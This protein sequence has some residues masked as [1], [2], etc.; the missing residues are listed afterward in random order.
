MSAGA[1]WEVHGAKMAAERQDALREFVAVTG[2]EEDRAR[3]F[4]ESAGW[5]LQVALRG[6]PLR[7]VRGMR[8]AESALSSVCVRSAQSSLPGPT[9]AQASWSLG[10][11]ATRRRLG[12]RVEG[13]G[14]SPACSAGPQFSCGLSV[15]ARLGCCRSPRGGVAWGRGCRGECLRLAGWVRETSFQREPRLGRGGRPIPLPQLCGAGGAGGAVHGSQPMPPFC[16]I[17]GRNYLWD[18]GARLGPL[19]FS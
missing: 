19:H 12:L 4:L 11:F 7:V 1:V 10:S 13:R 14:P 15:L 9:L 3:F 8:S 5:D 6:G 17:T 18:C 16:L 2:A